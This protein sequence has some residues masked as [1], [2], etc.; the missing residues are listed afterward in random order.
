[1]QIIST[2]SVHVSHQVTH[3]AENYSIHFEAQIDSANNL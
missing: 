1:M 2:V 3:Q